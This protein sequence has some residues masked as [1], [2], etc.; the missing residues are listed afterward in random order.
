MKEIII[1]MATPADA[2]ELVAVYAPYVEKTE[3]T[4]EY[5][6][7][8]V[9]E[10]AW[11]IE[12]LCKR[13]PYLV[14]ELDGEIV[15]YAYASAFK[16]RAAYDWAVETSIYVKEGMHG[17]GI[18]KR[19]Y[20]QLEAYLK[21][22]NV[23]NTNACITYPNPQSI[24]FHERF[25][26]KTVA[27]FTACGYKNGKWCDMIWMEKH[28]ASHTVPCPQFVPFENIKETL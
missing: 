22:Q 11:R 24:A 4:F 19:L 17:K 6:V 18:G 27:H 26:Y 21:L 28:I 7:P 12:C 15:G 16:E 2:A 5:T 25:G 13:Y 23:T 8:S 1:R 3:I 20:T 10:F 9:A 14:A